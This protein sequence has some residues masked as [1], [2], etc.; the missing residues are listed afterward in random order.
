MQNKNWLSKLKGNPI[1][2]LQANDP[3]VC[4]SAL[5][6]LLEYPHDADEMQ[7]ARKAVLGHPSIKKLIAETTDWMPKAAGRN[8]DPQI[9]YFKLRM[10]SDFG[11]TEEDRG[12]A[13]IIKKAS[14]HIHD[15]MFACRGQTPKRPQK[16]AAIIKPDPYADAWHASPCN[17][18]MIA[19]A[20][21]AL[22]CRS[23]AIET[24]VERLRELWETPTGWFCHFFFVN[25]QFR[26]VN[27]G[28]PMA[29]IMALEVFSQVPELKESKYAKNAFA[30]LQ[31][32]KEYGQTLYYFGRSKK[33][34]TL[35]YPFVW[36]NGLYLADVLSRF[37]FVKESPLMK[38]CI[39][40]ILAAQDEQG[41]FTATSAFIPYKNWDFGNKRQPSPWI[42]FLCCRILKRYFK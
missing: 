40:W 39:D 38:E 37:D 23:K 7:L 24:A 15:G 5:T 4:Y 36:Y 3:W 33:F 34:W 11:L 35:K 20:L 41:R 6:E 10:L 26:K 31:F 32:H 17:S 21:I 28:C 42:T 22:N 1:N 8:S 27:A 18:P 13:S 19:Y 2:W 14:A 9:S 25:S 12:I 16:G 30:P 29:G